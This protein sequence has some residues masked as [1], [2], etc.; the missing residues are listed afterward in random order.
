MSQT[1]FYE[2]PTH[3]TTDAMPVRGTPAT[4]LDL[5][6]VG[7]HVERA[8]QR[9]RYQ[10]TADPLDYLLRKHCLVEVDGEHYT[11]VAGILC[12]GRDPQTFF[13]RATVDIGHYR[14]TS[15][16]S[17]EVV[18]LEKYIGGTIFDQLARIETYLWTNTH[19]G[20]TVP[21]GSF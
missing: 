9:R 19:H 6:K 15:P 13:P 5:D 21:P 16:V 1:I 3:P 18:H 20:M 2:P 10:G 4:L 12:F 11:T 7:A 14:G 17:Y 8:I